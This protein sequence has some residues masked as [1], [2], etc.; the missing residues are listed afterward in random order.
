MGP[1]DF[2]KFIG[3]ELGKWEKVVKEANIKAE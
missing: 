3:V 2:G 1:A